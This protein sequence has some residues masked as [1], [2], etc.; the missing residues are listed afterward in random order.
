MLTTL[1]ILA[2]LAG[3][4]D[5][6][7]CVK[8]LAPLAQAIDRATNEPPKRAALIAQAKLESGLWHW[9][10]NDSPRCRES[11]D[12][13]V[14]D[15]GKAW[16]PW[17]LHGTDRTGGLDRGARLML[18]RWNFALEY[19]GRGAEGAFALLATGHRCSWAEAPGRVITWRATLW[20]LTGE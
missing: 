18:A 4:N 16:G 9:V 17:Q 14:C 2:A 6:P 20:A 13:A 15:A 12:P 10:I 11:T 8:R 1:A 3:C 5:R 7:A 19:C